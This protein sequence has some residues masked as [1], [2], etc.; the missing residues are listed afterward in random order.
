RMYNNGA[1]SMA[2]GA[3]SDCREP[4]C[5]Q[6]NE[7]LRI[8]VV[9]RDFDVDVLEVDVHHDGKTELHVER[10]MTAHLAIDEKS[11]AVTNKG[12]G[13]HDDIVPKRWQLSQQWATNDLDEI[14]KHVIVDN[15][16]PIAGD[17]A[18]VPEH[19]R[20]KKRKLHEVSDNDFHI[21]VSRAHERQECRHPICI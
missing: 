19:G 13:K 18:V 12:H 7:A 5:R 9:N 16:L 20:D 3:R 21:A 4:E 14:E 15:E 10:K 17:E 1:A 2:D 11:E 6:P 8:R